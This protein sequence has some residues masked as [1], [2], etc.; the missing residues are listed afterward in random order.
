MTRALNAHRQA[1][2][3]ALPRSGE[4]TFV[5]RLAAQSK[6]L[7]FALVVEL[8]MTAR[9]CGAPDFPVNTFMAL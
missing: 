1:D 3:F 8:W 7:L 5:L 2:T 4:T 6:T 9:A